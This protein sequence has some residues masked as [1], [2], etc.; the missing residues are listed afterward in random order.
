MFTNRFVMTNE[1][2]RNK[3]NTVNHCGRDLKYSYF[4]AIINSKSVYF[5]YN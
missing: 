2:F 5:A 3:I 1:E 4:F